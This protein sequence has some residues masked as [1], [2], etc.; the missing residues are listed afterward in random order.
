MCSILAIPR[1]RRIAEGNLTFA[2]P[3]RDEAWRRPIIDG[4]FASIGRLLVA[5]ARFPRITKANV[6]RLDPL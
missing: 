5:F 2:Y 1:L 6:A 4:V 3:D